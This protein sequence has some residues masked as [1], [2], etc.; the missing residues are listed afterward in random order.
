MTNQ[1]W[2][3]Y[4]WART[5]HPFTLKLGDNL[6]DANFTKFFLEKLM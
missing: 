3:T 5:D 6:T 1:S 2:G 4:H